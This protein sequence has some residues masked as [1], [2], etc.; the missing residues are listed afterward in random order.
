[1]KICIVTSSFPRYPGDYGG[2]FVYDHALALSKKHEVHV[3]YLDNLKRTQTYPDAIIRHPISYPFRSYPLAQVK[4]WEFPG[5]PLLLFE[6]ARKL[7]YVKRHF[8]IEL[9]YP[10]WTIPCGYLCAL[11]CSR[12]PILLGIMGSDLKVFGKTTFTKPFIS[13][14]VTRANRILAVSED[15][16][17]EAI[18]LGAN[19]NAIEV[20]P[21]GVDLSVFKPMNKKELR[22]KLGIPDGFIWVFS[23]SLFRL[24]R[25]DWIIKLS[26]KLL[27]EFHFNVLILGDGP[28]R[29]RLEELA[30]SLNVTNVLFK[31][32]V[33]R[34]EVPLYLAASDVLLLFSETEG[35]PNCIEEAMASGLPVIATKVGGIPDIIKDG[36]NGYLV[37]NEYQAETGLRH[38]MTSPESAREMGLASLSFAQQYL[39]LEL[40]LDKILKLCE[41]MRFKQKGQVNNE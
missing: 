20:I 6:M 10:F 32:R 16:K 1:M 12:T 23:G 25:V 35:L 31:G 17:A 11:V 40:M 37:E 5:V 33:P 28:E 18:S 41:S 2:F 3:I 34:E 38:L 24:K 14:A 4:P 22:L 7:R 15:L 39:S 21:T 9:F 19:P 27:G 36:E 29:K 13:R 26:A 8:N 30:L